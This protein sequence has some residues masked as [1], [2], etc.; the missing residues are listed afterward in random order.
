[1]VFDHTGCSAL[2]VCDL[3]YRLHLLVLTP[4]MSSRF[5]PTADRSHYLSSVMGIRQLGLVDASASIS[6]HPE[7]N[8]RTI[9]NMIL[10]SSKVDGYH[11]TTTSYSHSICMILIYNHIPSGSNRFHPLSRTVNL[12]PQWTSPVPTQSPLGQ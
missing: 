11:L 3:F 8:K 1:M 7:F 2:L 10:W 6:N 4:A 12:S 5:G 9:I